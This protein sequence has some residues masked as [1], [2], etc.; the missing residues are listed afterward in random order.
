MTKE[1]PAPEGADGTRLQPPA[2]LRC[3]RV[4]VAACLTPRQTAP[5]RSA[6]LP[7]RIPATGHRH[8]TPTTHYRPL[9]TG[10]GPHSFPRRNTVTPSPERPVL[11]EVEGGERM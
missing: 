9:A 10:H 4:L 6:V 11:S 7:Y 8:E 2:P 5:P 1:Q 3:D